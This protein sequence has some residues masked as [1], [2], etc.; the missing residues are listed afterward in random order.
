MHGNTWADVLHSRDVFRSAACL[1]FMNSLTFA[2]ALQIQDVCQ[3]MTFL[4]GLILRYMLSRTKSSSR[5]VPLGQL[6]E[7]SHAVVFTAVWESFGLVK[8]FSIICKVCGKQQT[9]NL[10]HRVRECGTFDSRSSKKMI[11]SCQTRL[12]HGTC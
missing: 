1:W 9:H 11:Y 7:R 10:L 4:C 3:L 5:R 8:N 2:R 12:K 6:R